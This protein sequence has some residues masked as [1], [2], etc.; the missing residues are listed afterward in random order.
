MR[1]FYLRT[2]T[3]KPSTRKIRS[4]IIKRQLLTSRNIPQ[5]LKQHHMPPTHKIS[6]TPS[7]RRTRRIDEPA[8]IARRLGVNGADPRDIESI[9]RLVAR[10]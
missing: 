1:P 9:Q 8:P 10:A 4:P 2:P 7:I 5:S 3:L 6:K